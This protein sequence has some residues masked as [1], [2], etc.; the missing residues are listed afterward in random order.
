[1][2]GCDFEAAMEVMVVMVVKVEEMVVAAMAEAKEVV[3]TGMGGKFPSVKN[4]SPFSILSSSRMKRNN[5]TR[6]DRHAI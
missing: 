1:M 6:S 3:V 2:P 4:V 5:S